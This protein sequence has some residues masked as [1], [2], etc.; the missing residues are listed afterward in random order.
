MKQVLPMFYNPVLP[1]VLKFSGRRTVVL[2]LYLVISDCIG[3][4]S[5]KNLRHYY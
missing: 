5:F 4:V 3:L 2:I 1:D